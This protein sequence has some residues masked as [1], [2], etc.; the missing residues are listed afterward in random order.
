MQDTVITTGCA[1]TEVALFYEDDLETTKAG[2]PGDTESCGT[3]P[4]DEKL[5]GNGRHAGHSAIEYMDVNEISYRGQERLY[6]M[7]VV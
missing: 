1:L 4:D 5:G 3:P 2:V 6:P 7:G